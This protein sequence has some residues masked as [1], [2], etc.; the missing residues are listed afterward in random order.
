MLKPPRDGGR[1]LPALALLCAAFATMY[2]SLSFVNGYASSEAAGV[3]C[4]KLVMEARK[5]ETWPVKQRQNAEYLA[6]HPPPAMTNKERK[7]RLLKVKLFRRQDLMECERYIFNDPREDRWQWGLDKTRQYLDE[8]A[9][10]VDEVKNK[11][12][13]SR[14]DLSLPLPPTDLKINAMK[15]MQG[16][17]ADMASKEERK[18]K[19]EEA[20]KKSKDEQPK[21]Q[22][23]EEV[24]IEFMNYKGLVMTR[25]Q[26]AQYAQRAQRKK[27]QEQKQEGPRKRR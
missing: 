13:T 21:E 2:H 22:N 11:K 9:T 8:Q 1:R 17:S 3:D 5:K 16:T 15:R 6:R 27:Q 4:S 7:R 24:D 12:L 14:E 23:L 25:K 18:K 19:D 10:L 26:K 20:K